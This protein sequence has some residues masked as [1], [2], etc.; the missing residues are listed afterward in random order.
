MGKITFLIILLCTINILCAF[1]Q[2]DNTPPPQP[3]TTPYENPYPLMNNTPQTDN[4]P[5]PTGNTPP[6]YNDSASPQMNNNSPEMSYTSRFPVTT[7]GTCGNNTSSCKPFDCCSFK[8]FC[9]G[10]TAH[11]GTGCQSDY[12]VCGIPD[13]GLALIETCQTEKTIA[14]TY[15]DGPHEFTL[16]LLDT[17]K[18]HNILAT[19][20]IN[21][22][23]QPQEC[24]YDYAD[25]LKRMHKDGHQ[26]AHHTWSHPHLGN[27]TDENIDFQIKTL[28]I[29]FEK[30]LGFIPKYF[31]NPFGEATIRPRL[32]KNLL[33]AGFKAIALW[34]VDTRDWATD[35]V[36]S[37]IANFPGQ[38][39]DTKPHIVLNH[40]R[41]NTTVTKFVPD[42]IKIAKKLGYKFDTVAGCNGK[43]NKHDWYTYK[44]KPQKRDSTWHCNTN[45][46]EDGHL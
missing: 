29:A 10:T 3:S 30:I 33:D 39:N 41:I 12:G 23:N 36:T 37:I 28:N 16:Q 43:R 1:A 14:F 6:P 22:H 26:I 44:G 27:E 31:R 45:D 17:L 8:G 13:D 38:I 4:T 34:D 9:G 24:I 15:D 40:D 42:A 46:I 19:F 32:R 20:F 35:N 11:C 18:E 5:P 2:Y 7:D 21:G 25:I